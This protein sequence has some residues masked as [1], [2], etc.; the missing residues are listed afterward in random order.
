MAFK[1]KGGFKGHNSEQPREVAWQDF[2]EPLPC[3]FVRITLKEHT[4]E[5]TKYMT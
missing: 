1:T 2:T 4:E 3:S 5:H